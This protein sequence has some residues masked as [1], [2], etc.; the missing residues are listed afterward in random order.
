MEEE[1]KHFLYMWFDT[2]YFG[3]FKYGDLFFE[4]MPRYVG[5]SKSNRRLTKHLWECYKNIED[6]KI[7][8][9][10]FR[11]IKEET[12]EDP[13]VIILKTDLTVEEAK[14]IEIEYIAKIGRIIN[15]SGP[16]CNVTLGGESGHG[17]IPWNKGLTKESDDRLKR[18]AEIHKNNPNL[19]ARKRIGKL[20]NWYKAK[21][22]GTNNPAHKYEYHI[23][24]PNGN[25]HYTLNL[26]ELSKKFS[27]KTKNLRR[28]VSG[29]RRY[30]KGWMGFQRLCS[31]EIISELDI[32]NKYDELLSNKNK[33]KNFM[34]KDSKL[35]KYHYLLYKEGFFLYEGFSLTEMSNLF[36]LKRTMLA[37]ISWNGH[38]YKGYQVFREEIK[39]NA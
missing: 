18:I 16:L 8:G 29:D 7:K 23:F 20:N 32:K 33:G 25:Y 10:V 9:Q 12:G 13:K 30:Y 4:L 39:Q 6:N 21:R 37:K 1:S 15:E 2:R 35:N 28:A 31:E 3:P 36:G 17:L 14:K 11:K 24:D 27:I 26:D 38:R 22:N 5:I 34:G 19:P